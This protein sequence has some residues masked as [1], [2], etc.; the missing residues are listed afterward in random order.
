MTSTLVAL[1][2]GC[3]PPGFQ[4]TA[5]S[6]DV[7]KSQGPGDKTQCVPDA[8][9][10]NLRPSADAFVMTDDTNLNFGFSPVSGILKNI[11][12][13]VHVQKGSLDLSMALENPL[14]PRSAFSVPGTAQLSKT[15]F[16]FNV[17]AG[18]INGGASFA[19]Q[20]SLTKLAKAGVTNLFAQA[21]AAVAKNNSVWSTHVTKTDDSTHYRIP[22]GSLA[23]IKQGDT[24]NIYAYHYAWLGEECAST[25]DTGYKLSSTPI[26][27]A[28]VW[29]TDLDS[30]TLLISATTPVPLGSLVEILNLPKASKNQVRALKRAVRISSVTQAGQ[31]S[32]DGQGVLDLTP[33][34]RTQLRDLTPADSSPFWVVPE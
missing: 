4:A 17:D 10:Y 5:R 24:F 19:A 15:N 21:A 29:S 18:L 31:V 1:S 30:S 22:A 3:A 16:S 7:T 23:G 20:T 32:V 13:G 25:L 8:T 9:D 2:A 27:T 28:L 6:P 12:L 26:A 33:F 14:K 34:I 11:G